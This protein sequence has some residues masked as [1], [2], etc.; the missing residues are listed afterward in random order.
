MSKLLSSNIPLDESLEYRVNLVQENYIVGTK[1]CKLFSAVDRTFVLGDI[2]ADRLYE[3]E[4][5]FWNPRISNP[6]ATS[7]KIKEKRDNEVY[8]SDIVIA[9]SCWNNYADF[10]LVYFFQK[11]KSKIITR[12]EASMNQRDIKVLFEKVHRHYI[13]YLRK[14]KVD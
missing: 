8:I 3:V 7:K 5:T 14:I 4:K 13:D 1:N 12:Y 6:F 2:F 9:N 10:S 11:L